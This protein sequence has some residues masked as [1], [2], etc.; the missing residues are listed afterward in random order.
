[1]PIALGRNIYLFAGSHDATQNAAIIH[2][3]LT[4]RL[5][6]VNAYDWLKYV[7]AA[8]P[9]FLSS[10]IWELLTYNLKGPSQLHELP[11]S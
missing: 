6:E 1:M 2:S 10:R 9:T 8:K 7:L 5:H 4:C 11:V 3:L